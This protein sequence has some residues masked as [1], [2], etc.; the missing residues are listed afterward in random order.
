MAVSYRVL[1]PKDS[2]DYRRIRLKSLKEHPD[3][4]TAKYEEQVQL[5]KLYFERQI[6]MNSQE[7]FM[8][9]AYND[10]C[11]VGICGFLAKSDYFDDAGTII[12]MYV[13][14]EWRNRGI[15]H[16]LVQLIKD[17]VAKKKTLTRIVLEVSQTN[18]A[19]IHVDE[20]SGFK[21]SGPSNQVEKSWIM[22][23][24]MSQS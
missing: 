22:V 18:D 5:E 8:A 12:Q 21:K 1:E 2:S 20:G 24:E 9:G 3:I 19:A 17:I 4:F 11:L 7:A 15:G 13:L 23:C 16:G 14:P 10:G 6:E